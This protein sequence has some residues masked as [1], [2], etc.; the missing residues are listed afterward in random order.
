MSAMDA[1]PSGAG[2]PR[3]RDG[4]RIA[5]LAVGERACFRGR[6]GTIR[7]LASFWGAKLDRKYVTRQLKGDLIAVYRTA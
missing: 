1:P 5:A 4:R 7:S 2:R 6:R 3:G